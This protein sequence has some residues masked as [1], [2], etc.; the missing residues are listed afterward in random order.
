M[1][2]ALAKKIAEMLGISGIVGMKLPTSIT[3]AG[4][5]IANIKTVEINGG[6]GIGSV[7]VDGI[8]VVFGY[9]D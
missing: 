1:F 6:I 9:D 2:N 8:E 5:K 3:V 4:H 7:E